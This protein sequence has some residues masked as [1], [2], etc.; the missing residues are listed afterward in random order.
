[1]KALQALGIVDIRHGYGTYVGAV[2][3]TGLE[4]GL[5]FRGALSARGDLADIRDLLE[6]R[7]VLETGLV[8][9]VLAARAEVDLPAME[10]AV[11]AME[12]AAE[13]GRFAPEQDW[14]F[15]EAL[16][17]PLGNALVLELL[18]VFWRVFH[19]LDAELPGPAGS[20]AATAGWH[21]AI[22]EALRAQDATALRAAIR[23]H[24]NG[25]RVRVGNG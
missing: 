13:H 18:R 24:F 25:I 9:R 15:H 11:E 21:R 5:T 8:D 23:E 14:A 10:A 3:L 4:A 22:L 2:P 17:R 12:R 16:H 1:M 7:E 20:P 6:V 19:S